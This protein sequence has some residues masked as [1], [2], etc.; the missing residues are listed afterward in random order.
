MAW[1][2]V[3]EGDNQCE[4]R[5]AVLPNSLL[6]TTQGASLAGLQLPGS[7]LLSAP[8]PASNSDVILISVASQGQGEDAAV[9]VPH[10]GLC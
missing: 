9:D 6:R 4:Q 8:S 7:L 3:L 2:A 5:V 10:V 1:V